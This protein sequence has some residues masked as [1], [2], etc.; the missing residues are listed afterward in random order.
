MSKSILLQNASVVT[1]DGVRENTAVLT[2]EGRI[3]TIGAAD[4]ANAEASYDLSG[5]ILYPGF[6]DVHNHGAV[7][8]DTIETDADGLRRVSVFLASQGVT[9]WLP[10][11]VPAPDADYQRGINAVDDLLAEPRGARALGVHY[12]GP[13]VNLAQCGALRTKHFKTYDAPAVLDALPTLRTPGARHMT[14]L[15]PEIAGGLE[16]IKEL[17]RRDWI[18]SIGHTRASV[19]E[20]DR[21]F[22]MGARHM[23]HF[24]NAMP[25][26]HHRAPGP[27]GWGLAH[28]AVTCDVIADGHHVEPLVLK[29]IVRCKTPERVVL[30][31]DSVAPTGQGDGDYEMWGEKIT[32]TGGRTGN[33]RGSI[34]GSVSTMLDGVRCMLALARSP[35]EVALMAATNPARLLNLSDECGSIAEGRR[36]DLTAVDEQGM[37]RFTLVGGVEEFNSLAP[38]PV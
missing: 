24:M 17:R 37:V 20:L 26:L 14:T 30:I 10:T 5:L 35:V 6:I 8:V 23:T 13:F 36:A 25:G 27:V 11:F 33:E 16:L 7:G 9:S 29:S 28:D 18:V 12:E 3:R 38:R 31:S 32:V 22:E 19:E 1:P 2:A 34:A 15:A 21:A 4:G